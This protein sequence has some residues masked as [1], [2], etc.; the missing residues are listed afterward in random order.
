VSPQFEGP[1]EAFPEFGK[2]RHELVARARQLGW[3]HSLRLDESLT[4]EGYF[5]LDEHVPY[6][7]LPDSLAGLDCLE[8]GTG[9]G[10][11][12]FQMERRGAR[13]VT[14]TDIGAYSDTDFGHVHGAPAACA[15]RSPDGE[16]GEPYRLA[17]TL[18]GSRVRYRI[19]SVYDLRPED[20]GEFDVVFCASMLMHLYAPLLALQR[21][22]RV[23]RN[24]LLLSTQT[25]L[26]TDGEAV[27]TFQGHQ[28]PYVHWIPS[29]TCLVEMVRACGYEQVLRGPTFGLPLRDPAR[30]PFRVVHTSV[31]AVK[32]ARRP[33]VPLPPPR[34]YAESERVARLEVVSAPATVPLGQPFDVVV[35][36]ENASPVGWRG[37]G[38]DTALRLDFE[39]EPVAPRTVTRGPALHRSH[40]PFVDYLPAG[41]STLARLRVVAPMF[42][43]TLRIRPVVSQGGVRFS[44][45]DAA[46]DVA[47]DRAPAPSPRWLRSGIDALRRLP[48]YDA[49]RTAAW[50]L[51][52][53]L[54]PAGRR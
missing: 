33:C 26:A 3:Y 7:L 6:F 29:P 10:Y 38:E 35:R 15:G 43:G 46:H 23:C 37:D 49:A 20:L 19:V 13:S 30:Y 24:T 25:D 36:V 48:R 17:A 11:W 16:Y 40:L 21:M 52:L 1:V 27:A 14:A 34:R 51:V 47:V 12:S 28:I 39:L 8:I 44:S 54:P 32:D 22:A 41:L 53:R 5:A 50:K 9:N 18:L 31:V 45:N 2:P 4:T 42:P